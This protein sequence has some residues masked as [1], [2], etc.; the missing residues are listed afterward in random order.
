MRFRTGVAGSLNFSA[1]FCR[2]GESIGKFNNKEICRQV[3]RSEAPRSSGFLSV[4][5]FFDLKGN[6]KTLISPI[7]QEK[8]YSAP[9]QFSAGFYVPSVMQ[10][11]EIA[12]VKLRENGDNCPIQT[13][14]EAESYKLV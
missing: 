8:V 12:E 5:L 1:Q 3:T 13:R 7:S 9:I 6:G 4:G 11:I 14:F 10:A 2:E